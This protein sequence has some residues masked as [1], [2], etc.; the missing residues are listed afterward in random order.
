MCM[1]SHTRQKQTTVFLVR[2]TVNDVEVVHNYSYSLCML[3]L[4]YFL[5]RKK[6]SHGVI[7]NQSKEKVLTLTLNR[8]CMEATITAL[9]QLYYSSVVYYITLHCIVCKHFLG[10]RRNNRSKDTRQSWPS[11]QE[12]LRFFTLQEH[13]SSTVVVNELNTDSQHYYIFVETSK[14]N[15]NPKN[16]RCRGVSLKIQ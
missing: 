12:P 2:F 5:F 6:S 15:P 8:T 9:Q 13:G 16:Q 1:W 11:P 10:V 14:Q 4:F 7:W 3:F